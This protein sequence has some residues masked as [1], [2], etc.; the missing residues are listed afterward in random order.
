MAGLGCA[1]QSLQ[2]ARLQPVINGTGIMV[3]TNFG[4]AP[5][6]RAVMEAISKIGMQYNKL[7]YGLAEGSRG[8]RAAYLE[9]NLALLCGAEGAT[10]VNNNASALVLILQHF[11][12]ETSESKRGRGRGQIPTRRNQ[13]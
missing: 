4:R 5:L 2:G 9:Q 8:G 11:C 10:I 3:H 12:K 13:A 6:G 7:E 1:L